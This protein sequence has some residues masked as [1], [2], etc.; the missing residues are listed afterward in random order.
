MQ[1]FAALSFVGFATANPLLPELGTLIS[2]GFQY[3]VSSPWVIFFPGM[4]ILIFAIAMNL[5]GDG[6]RDALDPKNRT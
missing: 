6:L 5:L 3:A 4:A 2:N 1:V